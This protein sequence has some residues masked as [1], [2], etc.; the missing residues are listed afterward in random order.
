MNNIMDHLSADRFVKLC[1]EEV[2]TRK[3]NVLCVIAVLGVPLDAENALMR[4]VLIEK[5]K[6]KNQLE[7]ILKHA[8]E[9]ENTTMDM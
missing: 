8:T 4:K 1:C 7:E 2:S 5:K 3:K 6:L 9:K